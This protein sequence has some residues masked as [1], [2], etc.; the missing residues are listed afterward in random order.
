MS[1]DAFNSANRFQSAGRSQKNIKPT[2]DTY[3]GSVAEA[4]MQRRESGASAPPSQ[5]AERVRPECTVALACNRETSSVG[6]S[7]MH[8][9]GMVTMVCT[10]IIPCLGLALAMMGHEQHCYYER[11]LEFLIPKRPD[12]TFIYL[13]L[14]CRFAPKVGKIIDSLKGRGLLDPT[15]TYVYELLVPWMHAFDHDMPC[16]LKFNPLYRLGAGRRVGEQTEQLWAKMKPF[17]KIARYM[18]FHHFW[19][20]MNFL[21]KSITRK[22][23]ANL[24][25]TLLRRITHNEAKLG[26]L[27][28]ICRYNIQFR[29]AGWAQ[30]G[31]DCHPHS[32]LL[33][34]PPSPQPLVSLTSPRSRLRLLPV[35][36]PI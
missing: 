2:T 11:L 15:K 31:T 27:G 36:S 13:D 9:Y 6:R 18:A 17:A 33:L 8:F 10:H 35:A 32:P 19:D 30:Y 24:P 14:M 5:A 16:Q 20:G 1:T 25:T 34:F 4:E 12:L 23:Q 3:L 28:V 21:L 26:E 29:A 7:E 22:T